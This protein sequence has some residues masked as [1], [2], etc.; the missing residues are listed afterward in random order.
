[1]G[2]VFILCARTGK[3]ISTVRGISREE[4]EA[5]DGAAQYSVR[6]WECGHVHV[7]SKRWAEFVETKTQ[8]A[9]AGC[10]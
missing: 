7:W 10:P 4:F 8:L 3:P 1:M 5:L 6:C 9:D 2:T